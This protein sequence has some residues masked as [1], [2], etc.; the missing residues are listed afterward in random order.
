MRIFIIGLLVG[1][2]LAQLLTSSTRRTARTTDFGLAA[3][4]AGAEF[5][6]DDS[7]KRALFGMIEMS[8]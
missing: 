8:F 5:F 7:V 2:F 6:I 3:S 4:I 1:T